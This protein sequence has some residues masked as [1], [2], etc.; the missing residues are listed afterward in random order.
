M[1]KLGFAAVV[2][3]M[4][5]SQA[6]AQDPNAMTKDELLPLAQAE[7]VGVVYSFTSR[8]SRVEEA[9]EATYP[10]IDLQGF[11]HF[12]DRTDRPP[13]GRGRARRGER[14]CPSISRTRRVVIP[15]LLEKGIIETYVPPRVATGW[16]R[17]SS[18]RCWRSASRPR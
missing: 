10:G 8:I 11:G 2:A 3:A 12:V 15:E 6:A 9:F 5:A 14:G 7:G 1:K 18:R 16:P 13:D 4:V 17:A